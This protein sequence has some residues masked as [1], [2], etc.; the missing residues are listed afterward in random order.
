MKVTLTLRR[1]SRVAALRSA[2]GLPYPN[3]GFSGGGGTSRKSFFFPCGRRRVWE[4]PSFVLAFCFPGLGIFV[5][6]R[7]LEI[8][9]KKERRISAKIASLIQ[10]SIAV[11]LIPSIQF[12]Q[13]RN[14]TLCTPVISK[15]LR[16]R[17]FL[18]IIMSSRRN[19]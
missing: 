10:V 5:L 16:Q 17:R 4:S 14:A 11:S 8:R 13:S 2:N 7:A 12:H 18:H 9:R 15:R 1:N 19:M 6:V 3:S